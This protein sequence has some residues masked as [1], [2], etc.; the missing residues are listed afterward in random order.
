MTNHWLLLVIAIAHLASCATSFQFNQFRGP[1][2][3]KTANKQRDTILTHNEETTE[4][5]KQ[6]LMRH[7]PIVKGG[8]SVVVAI[9]ASGMHDPSTVLAKPTNPDAIDVRRVEQ[10]PAGAPEAPRPKVVTLPS[11]VQY[12]DYDLGTGSEIVNEG[13]TVQF[14]WVLRRSNGYFVDASSNYDDE[15]FI[16]KVGNTKKVIKGIDEGI[17]GM[18]VGGVRRMNIPPELAF[19]EGVGEGKPGPMPQGFGPQRQILT[20]IDKEVWYF[21]IKV[22]KIK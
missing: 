11:G 12:F 4:V 16:Y 1:M 3:S 15:P 10:Q 2:T 6:P 21:E 9:F 7:H 22:T 5:Q 19:V 8:I 20:R 13:K 17:R 14:Q 18:K